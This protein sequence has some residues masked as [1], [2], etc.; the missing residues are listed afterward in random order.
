MTTAAGV[1]ILPD[2]TFDEVG[3]RA[4]DTLLVPGSVEIDSERRIH[5]ITEPGTVARVKAL[6]TRTRR[7]ASV[8]VGAHILAAAGLLDGKRATTHWSTAQRLADDHPAVRVDPDPIFIREQG[9]AR[10]GPARASA[11]AWICPSLSSRRTSAR[12]S[13]CAWPASS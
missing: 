5:P 3:A 7:V 8:C 2:A 12:A 10:S 1:R 6:A 9:R 13:R 11:P 4:I